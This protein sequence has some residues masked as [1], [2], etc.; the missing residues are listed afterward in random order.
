MVYGILN[1]VLAAL[2]LWLSLYA[3]KKMGNKDN[4]GSNPVIIMNTL[5]GAAC[6]LMGL[7]VMFSISSAPER[8]T[9]FLGKCMYL[10]MGMYA[11]NFC[12]YCVTFPSFER[13]T[14]TRVATLV[15][16]ALCI[17]LLF[18]KIYTV[19]ITSFLGIRVDAKSL[20][21]GRL[22]N[23]FPYSWYN[24]Y[25]AFMTFCMPSL[26]VIIMLLRSENRS[27]RLDH[28]K[29][30]LTAI[31]LLLAW[32]SMKLILLASE[33]V[34]LF[35][36]IVLAGFVLAQSVI[37]MAATQNFLYDFFSASTL[38]LKGLVCY[39]LPSLVL[40]TVFPF[41][42]KLYGTS[43]FMFLLLFLVVIVAAAF[44]SYE[45]QKIFKRFSGFHSNQYASI[46]EEDLSQMD[47][48]DDPKDV[49]K[50]MHDIF[51]Q[52][53]GMA[54]FRVLIDQGNGEL[55]SVYDQEGERRLKINEK[56]RLFDVLLNM[57]SQIVLKSSVETGY[58]FLSIKSDL[59]DF[60]KK[61]HSDAI[62]LLNEG[63][64]LLG[65]LV[66]GERSGG[67]IYSDYDYEVFKKLYSYLW[68]F[69]YY[70]KNIGNQ[71]IVGT[72]NREIHMSEQIIESIQGN[73]D[74]IK[75]KKYDVGNIMIHAHNIGGEF[76]DLVKL[77]DDK[78][79]FVMGDLSGK[80]ISASMSMVIVKSII[81]TYLRDT[82][83]FK[84]LVEKVNQFIRFN[85]PKGTFMEG[86]FGLID[87]KDNTVYYI[88]CGIPA[89]FLYTRAY[90]NIIEIQ[91]EG[92]VLGFVK[93][94]SPYIKVK[95]VKLNPGDILVTC[96][97]GLID[98]HSP[99]GE[100][101]GKDR[102][103]KGITE[104]TALSAQNIAEV[105]F[106]NLK[107]F[108]TTVGPEDDVSVLVIKLNR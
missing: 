68:V 92:H 64:H 102:I 38:F 97:D 42:W 104:N 19:N 61:T 78:H 13:G 12:V 45:L 54:S 83:D 10:F 98:A 88:N 106:E 9:T 65:V 108:I 66:L 14:V 105:S 28:Q 34:A 37:V 55:C 31:A 89:M 24:F 101:F 75:N 25:E 8:L 35:S 30:I 84:R 82:S 32:L 15:G 73:M 6:V 20:F 91:G 2:L 70:L 56:D 95:K 76:I 59:L 23:Y 27:S 43:K 67:N 79:V 1:F 63:R 17:W 103:Q 90:N 86:I 26:A 52:S 47:Y 74:L 85:L 40:G 5:L 99:R 69:G 77:S 36:S 49:V 62:I 4:I 29:T 39:A 87:F 96:T 71:E 41:I 80:G 94:I 7:T 100:Q 81:R 57:D 50:K 22:T 93:D 3:D 11:I 44:A 51:V 18:T 48:S 107:D 33:R 21:T 16:Y 53:I 58:H 60:F 46:L 72:V